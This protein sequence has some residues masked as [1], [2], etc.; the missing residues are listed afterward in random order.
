MKAR[1]W[2]GG[3]ALVT[4]CTASAAVAAVDASRMAGRLN[5]EED[6]TKVGVDVRL[7]VGGLMGD[8]GDRTK[9]GPLVGVAAGAQPWRNLGIEAGVE[10]QR[11]AIDDGRIGTGEAM[12]RY[13]LGLLAKAGPL[14]AQEKLRPYVGA[15]AGVSYLNAT[16]GAESLYRNDFVTEVPIAAGL[17]YRFSDTVFAGARASYRVLFGEEFA[18][19]ANA[20]TTGDSNGN[21]LNITATLGGRF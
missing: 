2:M 21:L 10:G 12:Y 11:M 19:A 8:A 9:A 16:S 6:R 1:S 3:L 4:L 5:Y 15:G 17:D 20:L 14:I 18:N 7:G 13:N